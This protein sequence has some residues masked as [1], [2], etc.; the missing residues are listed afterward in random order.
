V[1]VIGH[2]ADSAVALGNAELGPDLVLAVGT[3]CRDV[4]LG[5]GDGVANAGLREPEQRGEPGDEADEAD[6]AVGQQVRTLGPG[7]DIKG[8][9]VQV[10][11]SRYGGGKGSPESLVR[12]RADE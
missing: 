9:T 7:G 3:S 10:T 4:S 8:R 6:E 12:G 2:A 5:F 1:D 11:A